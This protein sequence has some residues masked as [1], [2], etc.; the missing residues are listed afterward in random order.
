[1]Y[2]FSKAILNGAL[3]F[4][5]AT[6]APLLAQQDAGVEAWREVDMAFRQAM[7][8]E[9]LDRRGLNSSIDTADELIRTAE[10]IREALRL[11]CD[12]SGACADE[13]GRAT[14]GEQLTTLPETDEQQ[15]LRNAEILRDM[16]N[17]R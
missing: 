5:A 12:F 10:D 1:M 9:L 7:I 6:S 15:D 11:S 17:G 3:V 8:D 2:N 16:R 13:S 4:F 14:L